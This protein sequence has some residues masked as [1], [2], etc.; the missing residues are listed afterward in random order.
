[1]FNRI[2]NNQ[3]S[4]FQEKLTKALTGIDETETKEFFEKIKNIRAAYSNKETR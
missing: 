2:K 3:S 1:M 4:K